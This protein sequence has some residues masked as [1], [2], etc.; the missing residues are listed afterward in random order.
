MSLL[1]WLHNSSFIPPTEVNM[2]FN[3]L[4]KSYHI[5]LIDL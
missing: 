4:N 5:A 3:N 1:A 2:I